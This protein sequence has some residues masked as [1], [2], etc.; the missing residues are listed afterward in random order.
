MN[1]SHR[2]ID[3]DRRYKRLI[4][5][6]APDCGYTEQEAT[7]II[8][9]FEKAILKIIKQRKKVR[10]PEF[11]MFIPVAQKE[12]E[13]AKQRQKDL[14]LKAHPELLNSGENNIFSAGPGGES[15]EGFH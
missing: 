3:F 5:E 15:S 12:Y 10:I 14:L 1:L 9:Q 8:K 2:N 11:G 7:E 4:K 6:I 13:Q